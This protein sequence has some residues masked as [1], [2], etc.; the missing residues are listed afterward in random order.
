MIVREPLSELAALSEAPA[1]TMLFYRVL[2]MFELAQAHLDPGD[3]ETARQN[4][5]Q[6]ESL[7]DAESFGADGRSW[8]TGAGPD[9]AGRR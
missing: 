5:G 8:L 6:A 3:L 4:F 1:E 2:A 9:R 7:V